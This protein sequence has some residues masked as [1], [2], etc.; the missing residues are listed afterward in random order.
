LVVLFRPVP[1]LFRLL[2]EKDREG[3]GIEKGPMWQIVRF[4][5]RGNL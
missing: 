2:K 4:M 1:E 5:A 3:V